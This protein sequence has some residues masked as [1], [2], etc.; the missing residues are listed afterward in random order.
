VTQAVAYRGR[1]PGVRCDPSLP[2]PVDDSIHLD[3]A[4][5]VGFAERGPVD[6]PQPVEDTSQYETV[7]GD[8]LSLAIDDR[9]VPVYAALPDAVRSF[10]DNGGRRAY[11]V[12]VVGD[13]AAT[14]NVPVRVTSRI[15]LG[16]GQAVT[17]VAMAAGPLDSA[18]GQPPLHLVASSPGA[19]A[20]RMTVDVDVIDTVLAIST[21][22]A[23]TVDLTPASRRLLDEGDAVLVRRDATWLLLWVPQSPAAVAPGDGWRDTDVAR[24]LRADLTVRIGD[25]LATTAVERLTN[26]RLGPGSGRVA[27]WTD[28]LQPAGGDFRRDRSMYL[29]AP[30]ATTLVPV[31]GSVDEPVPSP[32]TTDILAAGSRNALAVDGL[33][34]FDAARLFLDPRLTGH[35]VEGLRLALE[36]LGLDD[37][38]RARGLH[39]LALQP[40]VAIVAMPDLYQRPWTEQAVLVDP[41]PA[42]PEPQPPST[43]VGFQP[44]VTAPPGQVPPDEDIRPAAVLRMVV[45]PPSAYDPAGLHTVAGAAADLCAARADMVAVLGLPRHAGV[46]DA[47]HLA[48]ALAARRSATGD[49][50]SYAGIWH[51]WGAVVERRSLSLAP[52]RAVPPDGAIAG[53]IAATELARGFWIEPA[54][55]PLAGFVAADPLDAGSTLAMFDRAL[56]VVRRRPAGF[57]ATSSH[58]MSPDRDLL[59][60][61]VLRLLIWVRKL[62]LREGARFVF[63]PDDERFRAQVATIFRRFLEALRVQGALAAYQVEVESLATRTLADEG[64][65][66]IDLK[67]APTSPI[68]FLTVTLLRS[69]DGLLQIGGV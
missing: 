50:A 26:L 58:S 56:N 34:T 8:D 63:E 55:R 57:V 65:L 47:Q 38:P 61:T 45:D 9:G 13:S 1:L 10:F 40:E 49:V 48:D 31:R 28:V 30:A 62:C 44:C 24:L 41:E 3:V 5:F 64:K 22:N 23:G 54:G 43:P 4:A 66:R 11:V 14:L 25:V 52:L 15:P 46:A 51:P 6:D 29:R 16:G 12:R 7:F 36:V 18:D 35:T 27:S 17:G 21:N 37:A 53:T 32:P 2:R 60:L 20:A 67:L 19:W 69:G 68:E 59:Q 33:E 42:A 39:A